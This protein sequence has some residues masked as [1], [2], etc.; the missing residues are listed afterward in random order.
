[1]GETSVQAGL[2]TAPENTLGLAGDGWEWKEIA[3]AHCSL[4]SPAL[5]AMDKARICWGGGWLFG[6]FSC[7]CL[8]LCLPS[9]CVIAIAFK[10]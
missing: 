9:I 4:N 8:S 2:E 7:S 1:M 10:R 6:F 3:L 5:E